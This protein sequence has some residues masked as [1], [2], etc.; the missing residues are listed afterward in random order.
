MKKELVDETEIPAE[1]TEDFSFQEMADRITARTKAEGTPHS[2]LS[3]DVVGIH[4]PAEDMGRGGIQRIGFGGV[5]RA[6]AGDTLCSESRLP[7]DFTP[8]N[9][10]A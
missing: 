5:I 7:R 8:S 2:E 1:T 10:V 9:K 4:I 3:V 6:M